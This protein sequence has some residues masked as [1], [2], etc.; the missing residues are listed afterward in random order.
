MASWYALLVEVLALGRLKNQTRDVEGVFKDVGLF[1][2]HMTQLTPDNPVRYVA[3]A[4]SLAVNQ[5]G[6]LKPRVDYDTWLIRGIEQA[7]NTLQTRTQGG[8]AL[9]ATGGLYCTVCGLDWHG[10]GR[11]HRMGQNWCVGSGI[12]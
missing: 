2:A 12:N 3:D 1:A 4:G 11:L 6:V 7:L 9:L 8:M 5:Y 10:L